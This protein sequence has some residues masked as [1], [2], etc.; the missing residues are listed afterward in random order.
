MFDPVAV[1]AELGL[2]LSGWDTF[3]GHIKA[4]GKSCVFI[5]HN[6]RHAHMA[7]DRFV[8]LDRGKNI[9]EYRKDELNQD[10]LMHA[11][12]DAASRRIEE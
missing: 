3:I 6:L 11:L 7:S 2:G 8:L 4:A 9:G 5:S 10:E 1:K 12:M